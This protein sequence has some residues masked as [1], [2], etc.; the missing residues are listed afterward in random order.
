MKRR[1]QAFVLLVSI[2]AC[3]LDSG[4]DGGGSDAAI[5]ACTENSDC[6]VVPQSCCGSCGAATR[7]DAVAVSRLDLDRQ[8]ADACEGT[9]GCPACFAETDPLLVA[10]CR[11]NRC[12]LV[13][14]LADEDVTSCSEPADCTLRFSGCC[15]CA[16]SDTPVISIR[17]DGEMSYQRLT[18]DS[19]A[20]CPECEPT[21]GSSIVAECIA[22]RCEPA[23]L[24]RASP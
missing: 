18:C 1:A 4:G 5:N 14:L 2:S 22:N 15:A 6:V 8:R 23:F 3:N 9:G 21:F 17:A 13:D 24:L 16:P 19:D 7:G 11:S 20:A 12:E 10:T